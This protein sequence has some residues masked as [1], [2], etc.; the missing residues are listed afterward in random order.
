MYDAWGKGHSAT[1]S[2]V[3]VLHV[4]VRYMFGK[5]VISFRLLRTGMFLQMNS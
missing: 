1:D 3:V 5:E 2:N 4:H